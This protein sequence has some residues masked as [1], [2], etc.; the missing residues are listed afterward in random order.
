MERK[1]YRGALTL[2]YVNVS[3]ETT[4][5]VQLQNLAESRAVEPGEKV[6]MAWSVDACQV[7]SG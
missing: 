3:E 1:I 2:I 7:L 6:Y 5:I 4:L